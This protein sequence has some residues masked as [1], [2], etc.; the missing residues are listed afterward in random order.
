MNKNV[1]F[2]FNPFVTANIAMS[3]ANYD[4]CYKYMC[5]RWA[6]IT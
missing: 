2:F 3:N 4:L 5:I 6:R 1:I